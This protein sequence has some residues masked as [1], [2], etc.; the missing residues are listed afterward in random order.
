MANESSRCEED[1]HCVWPARSW[2]E[3]LPEHF[4]HLHVGDSDHD[5]S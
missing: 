2:Y 5:I 3:F 1:T 4:M